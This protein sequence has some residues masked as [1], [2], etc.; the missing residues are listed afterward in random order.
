MR[1]CASVVERAAPEKIMVLCAGGAFSKSVGDLFEASARASNVTVEV[2]PTDRNVR[3]A[4]TEARAADRSTALLF[5]ALDEEDVLSAIEAG[6]DEAITSDAVDL[7]EVDRIL[8]RTLARGQTRLYHERIYG[9]AAHAEKLTALGTLVAGVAHE[10][11]NPCSA[12]TLSLQVVKLRLAP[13][14]ELAR[15]SAS[16]DEY[17]T[18]LRTHLERADARRF[19][20][21]MSSTFEDM[22][23]ATESIAAIVSDLRLFARSEEREAPQHVDVHALIDQ[24]LRIVGARVS[25]VA[26]VERDYDPA[27]TFAYVQRSRLAQVLTN[28]L[29]NAAQAMAEIQRPIHRVRISTRADAEG[30]VISI[31]DTGPG[32]APDQL[33]RIFDPFFTTKK[34]G[35]GT[36]L[37]LALSSDL[38]RRMGGQILVESELGHGATFLLYIPIGRPAAD[39]GEPISSQW[40]PSSYGRRA[41][42]L[43]IDD[44]ERV[45]RSY[46]R[47]LRD[48]YDVLLATDGQEAIDLLASGSHA[49]AI[50][51][52][53]QM[54]DVGGRRLVEWLRAERPKLVKRVVVATAV[55]MSEADERSLR[56]TCGALLYKPVS[57]DALHS[58]FARIFRDRGEL[59]AE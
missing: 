58:A 40:V 19:L 20:P 44:D 2:V 30:F 42:I 48:R 26:H 28:I 7:P 10:I 29:V 59:A 35:E 17:R 51:T 53:M 34:P 25:S 5:V 45:L 12:L 8:R 41:V 38:V 3:D 1:Y 39:S 56:E 32:I 18:A 43:A 27:V 55:P 11:N 22:L 46:A 31:A 54:A 14:F 21:D 49:D 15:V 57:F 24:V 23:R 13:L 4:V 50:L 6:A 37:G 52:D 47:A 36:G 16:P 33:D 9:A